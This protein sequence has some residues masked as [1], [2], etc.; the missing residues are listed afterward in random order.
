MS[1]NSSARK[2]KPSV[3]ITE[4][5]HSTM[6]IELAGVKIITDP[7]FTDPILGIVTHSRRMGMSIEELPELDLILISHAHFDHCDL[8]AISKLNKSATVIVPER[9]TAARIKKLGYSDV[10]ILA[11][12]ESRLVSVVSVTALPAR[13]PAPECTYVMSSG[14]S[15]VYFGGD[16]R[17]M[18]ELQQIGEKFD[19]TVA[20]LPM[21][22]LSFPYL[23]RVVM[24]P[25]DAAEAAVQLKARTAIPIHYNMTVTIPFLGKLFERA[26]PGTPEQFVA[27]IKRRNRYVKVVTL[28]PG[29]SWESE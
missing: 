22:G 13:H 25:V 16:T 18:K 1:K 17:Y 8:K 26:A 20:L 15:A 2:V 7:W 6:L 12:W 14:D 5:G 28:N 9:K 11:P 24:D 23:G 3:K 4:I 19:L 29:E 21:N 10:G 27:E